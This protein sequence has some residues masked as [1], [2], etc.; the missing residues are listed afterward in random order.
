[1]MMVKVL[2]IIVSVCC[3]T[4]SAAGWTADFSGTLPVVYIN[5]EA[6][7]ESKTEYVS[8]TGYVDGLQLPGFE[9]LGSVMQPLPLQIR[10]RGNWTWSDAFDKKPYKIKFEKKQ[11]PLG[12]SKSKH[13]ALLAHHDGPVA[14]FRN[15]TGFWL[16]KQLKL[17]YTPSEQPVELVLNGQYEGLY[18]L[19][20]TVRVQDTRVNITEQQDYEE[21][22]AK[23]TGGWLL[24]IDNNIS[25]KQIRYPVDH[26]DLLHFKITY[27]SPEN[28]SAVQYDYLYGQISEIIRS[29]FVADKQSTDWERIIDMPT[30]ARFYMVEEVLDHT[31]AFQGSCY[32]YKDLG[33]TRWK[34]GPVWDFGHAFNDWH[35]KQ[36]FMYDLDNGWE[37]NIMHEI[38]K[39][40]RF[41]QE[42]RR[43]W[44]EF[45]PDI[46]HQMQQFM[47]DYEVTIREAA[48]C[49]A[50]RW[51]VTNTADTR[52][53]LENCMTLLQQKIDFLE[54]EWGVA[55]GLHSPQYTA[56]LPH[57]SFDLGGRRTTGHR[58]GIVIYLHDKRA[59]K[60]K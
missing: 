7:I 41:Q 48:V 22:A 42:V 38:A 19:T 52:R 34:F 39:Y 15:A 31:E 27:H 10:G 17:P 30:L 5:T 55:N 54:H 12:L 46:Y 23:V 37:R 26:L 16:A 49:N 1:M 47:A 45:Y 28:L 58:K 43:V 40:P 13:F 51:N 9:S 6:P 56:P 20:E 59:I 57:D 3:L 18:F 33:E 32:F 21:D 8:G 35:P 36:Q 2:R 29:V 25:D 14:F 50:R 44:R 11:S 4:V 60:V 53:M 24:E